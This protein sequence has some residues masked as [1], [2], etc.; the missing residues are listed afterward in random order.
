MDRPRSLLRFGPLLLAGAARPRA[1]AVLAG[2]AI[3]VAVLGVLFANQ[4]TADRFDRAVDSPVIG[5]FSGHGDLAFRLSKP[6]TL[7]PVIAL[8]GVIFVICLLTGRLNGA[9]L[10]AAAVPAAD[11]L[12]EG[13]LKHLVHRTYLGQLAYP[14]GHT[15]AVFTIAATI[16]ILFLVPPQAARTRALRVLAAVAAYVVAGVVVIAVMALRWHYF[17][18]TVGGAAVGIGTVCGL[19]LILDLPA[20]RRRLTPPQETES[21]VQVAP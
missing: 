20:T 4:S 2:S 11:G 1:G 14:S 9:V 7:I 21:R 12:D 5:W 6:G 17:T 13:L 19:A 15:T 10:A 18:D 8:S 16:T 3:L